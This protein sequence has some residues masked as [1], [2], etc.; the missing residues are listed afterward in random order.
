MAEDIKNVYDCQ[1]NI[2]RI[3]IQMNFNIL[4]VLLAASVNFLEVKKN[5]H[6]KYIESYW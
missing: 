5:E 2:Y 1:S 3:F 6:K 4:Q